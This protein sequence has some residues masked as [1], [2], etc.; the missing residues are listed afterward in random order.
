MNIYVLNAKKECLGSVKIISELVI[1]VK[2]RRDK[3]RILLNRRYWSFR[4]GK[5][6]IEFIE[7]EFKS[8]GLVISDTM[9]RP[10]TINKRGQKIL[11]QEFKKR[12]G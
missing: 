8:H 9:T 12:F 1:V 5:T 11:Y 2:T 7:A 4:N 6:N 10:I 3:M